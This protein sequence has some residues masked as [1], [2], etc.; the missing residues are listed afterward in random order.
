MRTVELIL[1][2]ILSFI[3]VVDFTYPPQIHS[4]VKSPVGIVAV[5]GVVLF[6]FT[7]STVLGVLGIIAGFMVVQ[8]GGTFAP[9]YSAYDNVAVSYD[10]DPMMSR[11]T[12]LEETV[13]SNMVPMTYSLNGLF[14]FTNSFSD[15]KNAA[16]V[17]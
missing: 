10:N 15:V 7:K 13:V 5:L 8:R 16:C 14:S 4:L 9:K 12:T 11:A 1:A 3:I 6:L 2:A 17:S